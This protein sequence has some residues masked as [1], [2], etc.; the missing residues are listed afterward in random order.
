MVAPT[1]FDM[2]AIIR[3]KPTRYTYDH[4]ID[5]MDTIAFST[6]R[7]AYST[8]ITHYH[9]KDTEVVSDVEHIDFLALWLSHSIF[10]SK[11]LQVAKKYLTL[12]NQLHAGHDVCLSEM[13]LA[14]LYESLSDIVAQLKNLGDKGN[15][16]LFDPFWLLQLW[17]NATFE[18]NLPN[19]G[20]RDEDVEGILHR[21]VEGPR[22]AQL[23]PRDEWQALQLTFMS[24]I[25][26]FSKCHTFTSSMAP[27]AFRKIGPKWFT[28]TF[29]S[30]SKK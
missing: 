24:Y 4:D 20:L 28:R 30:P 1:L 2:S 17:L 10:C 16:L 13:I 15:L 9:D 7:A 27:F 19:K 23:T 6:T 18:A 29:P 22:L 3:L 14:S 12:A 8:H 11:S 26:M 5:S 21:R 25:M